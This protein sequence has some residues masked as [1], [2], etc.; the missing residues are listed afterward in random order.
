MEVNYSF[1]D[2]N[3]RSLSNF[4]SYLEENIE[5]NSVSHKNSSIKAKEIKLDDKLNIFDII[6]QNF[7]YENNSVLINEIRDIGIDDYSTIKIENKDETIEMNSSILNLNKEYNLISNLE[8]LNKLVGNFD[9]IF[10][11]NIKKPIIKC[12]LGEQEGNDNKECNCIPIINLDKSVIS[13]TCEHHTNENKMELG[14]IY[15]LENF[16][17]F[18]IQGPRTYIQDDNNDKNEEIKYLKENIVKFELN[19]SSLRKKIHLFITQ[20]RDNLRKKIHGFNAFLSDYRDKNKYDEIYRSESLRRISN[21]YS[22]F[23]EKLNLLLYFIM[24]RRLV[25]EYENSFELNVKNKIILLINLKYA[26]EVIG[27]IKKIA[28]EKLAKSIFNKKVKNTKAIKFSWIIE[29]YLEEEKKFIDD[30]NIFLAINQNGIIAIFSLII[31]NNKT[32]LI[33]EEKEKSYELI[34]IEK[35]SDFKAIKV[36]K[37]RKLLKVKENDN[38][39]I[40][41]SMNSNEFGKAYIINIKENNTINIKERYKIEII[42]EIKDVN[43]LYTSMEFTYGDENFLLNFYNI[44]YIWK[45]NSETSEIEKKIIENQN[46]INDRDQSYNYGPLIYEESRKLFIIQCFSPKSIIEFYK[47]IEEKDNFSFDKVDKI[48][49]FEKEENTLKNNNNYYIYKNKY[50]LLSSG[51]ME[52]STSGGIYIIDL[53]L[54]KKKSFHR[55]TQ[56]VSIN[57]IIPSKISNVIIV[58][59]IFNYKKYWIDKSK[60]QKEKNGNNIKSNTKNVNRGKLLSIEIKEENNIITLNINKNIEGGQF[61]FINCQKL[62]LNSYF[63][64]SIYKTNS[65]IKYLEDGKFIQYFQLNN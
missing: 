39:F 16:D 6:D 45:H 5:E 19:I 34:K 41:N 9:K 23:L 38:Y 55:F 26:L 35:I 51:K 43:G 15:L 2:S 52:N 48:I 13:F 12:L 59:S 60:K 62:F 50:L 33:K 64:T 58:S 11:Q 54:F 14:V 44:F 29:F 57:S 17:K 63:F 1:E 46:Q 56:C 47:I 4:G 20:L 49:E 28:F 36:T 31:F 61:Y 30:K 22:S 18:F 24:V 27:E 7:Q 53:E 42:Q 32:T 21:I 3:Q 10:L 25:Y 8:N 65:L 40:I 37:L